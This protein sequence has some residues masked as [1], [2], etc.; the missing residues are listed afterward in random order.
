MTIINPINVNSQGIGGTTGFGA[1]SKPE[2]EEV[3]EK[4]ISKAGEQQ[5]TLS[6]DEVLNFM[7]QSAAPVAK[8]TVDPSKYVDEASAD[9]IAGFMANFEDEV[10]KGLA[11]FEQE[12]AGVDISE[13]TKMNLVLAGINEKA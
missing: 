11:A 5:P 12:F 3:K 9:R 7:A 10:A 13:S 8:K 2:K 1:K 6:A 4:E